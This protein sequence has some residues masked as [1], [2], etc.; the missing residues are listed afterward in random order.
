MASMELRRRSRSRPLRHGRTT[1]PHA[2]SQEWWDVREHVLHRLNRTFPGTGDLAEDAVDEALTWFDAEHRNDSYDNPAGRRELVR[3]ESCKRL[4]KA[5]GSTKPPTKAEILYS[6]PTVVYLPRLPGEQPRQH[7]PDSKRP[8]EDPA[9]DIDSVATASIWD[10]LNADI[11]QERVY[12]RME[13]A[14]KWL[15]ERQCRVVELVND[16]KQTLRQAASTLG[17]SKDTVRRDFE[18]ALRSMK[19]DLQRLT[20]DPAALD[21]LPGWM[22]KHLKPRKSQKCSRSRETNLGSRPCTR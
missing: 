9:Y 11:E 7:F 4:G 16:E 3:Q 13:A 5:V 22:A 10:L 20:V 17:V 19:Q 8:A 15:P 1:H 21:L 6:A 14:R 2:P 18:K 12:A